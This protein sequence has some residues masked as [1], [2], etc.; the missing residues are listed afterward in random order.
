MI[1]SF[2]IGEYI[3]DRI[4]TITGY[5]CYPC[6]A[7]NDVKFPYIVYNR[8]GL[9]TQLTK[10]GY[11]EDSISFEISIYSDKY[12]QSIEVADAVRGALEVMSITHDDIL[13]LDNSTI[14]NSNEMW[15]NNTYVQN[16]VW[17]ATV[18]RYL[19]P[20]IS[21][22]NNINCDINLWYDYESHRPIGDVNIPLG[23]TTAIGSIRVEYIPTKAD[24]Y[25]VPIT[26]T[27]DNKDI[28]EE[29]EFILPDNNYITMT[30]NDH[31]LTFVVNQITTFSI[32]TEVTVTKGYSSISIP[33]HCSLVPIMYAEIPKIN[34]SSIFEVV[35]Y[36]NGTLRGL[37][38]GTDTIT[39]N[40]LLPPV[41][42]NI[43]H[44]AQWPLTFGSVT[45]EAPKPEPI[46][47][48]Y[49]DLSNASASRNGT[50]W[51]ISLGDDYDT[52]LVESARFSSACF[53]ISE[54]LATD[55]TFTTFEK[56]F[57]SGVYN[58]Q[59]WTHEY[60]C[61]TTSSPVST[62]FETYDL[63]NVDHVD[64]VVQ[65]C[66][67][68]RYVSAVKINGVDLTSAIEANYGADWRNTISWHSH[69]FNCYSGGSYRTHTFSS[70]CRLELTGL[71]ISIL[72]NM[73]ANG[74]NTGYTDSNQ[75][76]AQLMYNFKLIK[77]QA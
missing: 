57:Q 20:I 61:T 18:S 26:I 11:T 23:D 9:S 33:L 67:D 3:F 35:N 77:K 40:E 41:T 63:S 50:I 6:I 39:A 43:E 21:S 36:D 27:Q 19:T 75:Y 45:V 25:V 5:D 29:C 38:A 30:Y 48:E 65:I 56:S 7:D 66:A 16:I 51:T 15:Q 64:V 37:A 58:A 71:P 72:T 42:I 76:Y 44:D 49:I 1:K 53:Y 68:T 47:G 17:D 62:F 31:Q 32:D 2:K 54:Q 70:C 8:N 69:T 24:P 46:Y 74:N 13:E 10:D 55:D 59:P 28:T 34:T 52:T 14:V 73:T 22:V 12:A 60:M 4:K